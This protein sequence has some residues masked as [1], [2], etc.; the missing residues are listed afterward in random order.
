MTYR[1]V[2]REQATTETEK[3][4]HWYEEQRPGLGRAFIQ[5][6]DRV[7]DRIR[8]NPERYQ[9]VYRETRRAIAGRFPFGVFYRIEGQNIVVFAILDL[10]RDIA[11]WQGRED[12]RGR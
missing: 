5:Q 12:D 9:V 6:I 7:L 8:T 2:I 11:T 4:A 3:A 10:R 1:L